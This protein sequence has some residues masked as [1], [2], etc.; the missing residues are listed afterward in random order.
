MTC[1]DSESLVCLEGSPEQVGR[2]FGRIN[3]PD[4]R[5][6]VEQFYAAVET[7]E[8]IKRDELLRAGEYYRHLVE[9]YAPHWLEEAQAAAQAAG[10]DAEEF[11]TYQGAKYR[12]INRPE[13]F[14]YFSAPQHNADHVT[15]FHKNR[16]NMQR[17]QSA[18]VKGIQASSGPIYR[19]LAIGDTT[20]LGTMMGVNE[21]GLAAAADTGYDEPHPRLQGMMN[22]DLMRIIFE[23]A[24]DVDEAVAWLKEFHAHRVYAGGNKVGTNW[25]FADRRGRAIRVYQFHEKE[26]VVTRDEEGLMVMR[27]EDKRGVFVLKTLRSYHGKITAALHN[28]LSRREP[29][30]SSSNASALTAVI[31]PDHTELFT[32]AHVA[33]YR[34]ASTFYAPLYLG[35]TATPKVLV[36]GSL[37]RLSMSDCSA[38]GLF[39]E[40]EARDPEV[41]GFEKSLEE[42]RANIEASAR[43]AL[44]TE[45]EEAARKVLTEGCLR[46]AERVRQQMKFLQSE[47]TFYSD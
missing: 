32:Y 47:G 43:R 18:Y 20:D 21:K 16:D 14:T 30:L 28:R 40:G 3:A 17:P 8:G 4:I 46:L 38:K 31:P 11:L 36:D 6:E 25:M 26:M 45:G 33:L 5:R 24:A 9:R 2:V 1:E 13:C 23:R 44:E 22:T 35:V 10:V 15:L 19:F 39:S 37:S 7:E 34:A 27:D 42:E 41:S 29:V 12:G